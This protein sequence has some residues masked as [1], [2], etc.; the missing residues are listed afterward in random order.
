MTFDRASGILLHPTSLPGRYGIGDLGVEAYQF[1]DWLAAAGQRLW[2]ILPLGPT[3]YGD[4]PYQCFS[5]FAGNPMLI[6]PDY[7]AR[8]DLLAQW[9]LDAM[10]EFPAEQ[11]DFGPVIE[12]KTA[13]L[14]QAF[15]NFKQAG[16]SDAFRE[17][18]HAESDWVA[19][20]ALFMAIK[21]AHGGE[22]WVS[23]PAEIALR[24]PAA[25]DE[26]R[27]K[28]ADDVL[29]QT[30]LQWAFYSQWADLKAYANGKGIKIIGDV[31]IFVAHDSADVWANRELF[32]LDEGGNPIDIAGVPPDY[33][34][35]T[36]QRWGN[37]LYRWDELE[38]DGFAWWRERIVATLRT[39]DIVRLDHFRGFAGYWAVPSSEETAI[40]GAW[41]R[42]PGA[43]LFNALRAELGALPIIAEDL[44]VITPDVEA[45]RDG[46]EMPGMRILQFA[47]TS[48]A[49]KSSFLPHNYVPNTVAYSGSHDNDTS[50]GWYN[51]ASEEERHLARRY[52]NSSDERIVW[53][54]IRALQASV[55]DTV[56]IPLQDAL[57]LDSGARMN[58]PGRLGGNWAW[59]V[60]AAD[61]TAELAGALYELAETYARLDL[62][63]APDAV[64]PNAPPYFDLSEE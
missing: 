47:F 59:R 6:S 53:D 15:E 64:D 21:G 12:A 57:N 46:F 42:G 17:F 2:Q 11:V 51:A 58:M 5:A 24:E 13:L 16:L 40:N 37:P 25:L 14:R 30:F 35:A 7:L 62:P 10:P 49:S 48:R 23:W 36:G 34:S 43:K 9:D 63:V 32:L 60:R 61:L 28:L 55:A 56:V 31:P 38:R 50:R 27:E 1:I 4:S 41:R 3:G 52:L 8:Q 45:L 19:D 20:Y 33:F 54:M 29:F 22:S 44:G 26:W 18:Q 39:V